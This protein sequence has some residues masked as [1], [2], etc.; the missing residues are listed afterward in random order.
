MESSVVESSV[1]ESSV[2]FSVFFSAFFNVFFSVIFSRTAVVAALPG[3]VGRAADD[4]KVDEGVGHA[5]PAREVAAG[6]G[7][8]AGGGGREHSRDIRDTSLQTVFIQYF[9]VHNIMYSS[10]YTVQYYRF[11]REEHIIH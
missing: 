8:A 5:P 10:V 9:I 7:R 6:G 2:F 1:V 4:D 11:Q 3:C